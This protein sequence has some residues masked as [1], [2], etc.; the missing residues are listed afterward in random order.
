MTKFHVAGWGEGPP[1]EEEKK[2]QT[3]AWPE[4]PA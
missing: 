3:Q 1:N 4:D 2:G